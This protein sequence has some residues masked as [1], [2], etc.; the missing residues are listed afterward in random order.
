[1]PEHRQHGIMQEQVIK[2]FD[3]AFVGN[4]PESTKQI[5]FENYPCDLFTDVQQKINTMMY[6]VIV[7]VLY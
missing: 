6:I 1:M 2:R 7:S 4:N 3:S 5:L